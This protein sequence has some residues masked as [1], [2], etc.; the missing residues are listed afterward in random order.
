MEEVADIVDAITD[1]TEVLPTSYPRVTW[2]V[3]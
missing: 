3:E 1:L 2:L